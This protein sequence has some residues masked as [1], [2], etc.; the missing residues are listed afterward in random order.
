MQES[1]RN[2]IMTSAHGFKP[3]VQ[4][5]VSWPACDVRNFLVLPDVVAHA[6]WI[7]GAGGRASA[8]SR[9]LV[10]EAKLPTLDSVRTTLGDWNALMAWVALPAPPTPVLGK[11]RRVH[12]AATQVLVRAHRM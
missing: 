6:E 2:L 4:Q 9:E 12:Q 11:R 3:G 5:V 10:L 1:L 7:A 8:L